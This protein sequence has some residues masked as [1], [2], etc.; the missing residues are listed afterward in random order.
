MEKEAENAKNLK[1]DRTC[2]NCGKV[3]RTPAELVRHKG[4]K[5]PCLIRDIAHEDRLN[6]NRCI[7]CNYVFKQP[8]SLT[9]HK[10][11]CK[12]KNGGINILD[13]KIRHE[14]EIRRLTEERDRDKQEHERMLEKERAEFERKLQE[15][16]AMFL[17]KM[18]KIEEKMDKKANKTTNNTVNNITNNVV[19]I[20]I[21][22]WNEPS[23]DKIKFTVEQLA[24]CYDMPRL[25]FTSIYMNPDVPENHSIIPRSIKDRRVIFYQDGV[26]VAYTGDDLDK[27]LARVAQI[28]A[29]KGEQVIIR[30][31]GIVPNGNPKILETLPRELQERINTGI[32]GQKLTSEQVFEM[33]FNNQGR[34]VIPNL[35]EMHPAIAELQNNK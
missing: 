28:A 4:R 29:S 21:T 30:K 10:N 35:K 1:A 18:A 9:R 6:P 13:D 16:D 11:V 17:E 2:Y 7:Y 31:D 23:I 14:Q 3:F 5:T 27:M 15:R 8:Q 25:F 26:W 33:L 24:K 20:N 34:L 22:Q 32:L 12:I 19:N